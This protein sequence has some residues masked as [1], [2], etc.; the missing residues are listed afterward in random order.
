MTT[1]I[2]IKD[3]TQV[4]IN[5]YEHGRLTFDVK[6]DKNS[7]RVYFK[8]DVVEFSLD[9]ADHE[10]CQYAALSLGILI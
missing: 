9:R 10:D 8:S 5:Y 1:Q 3:G 4:E 2:N 6:F 7:N